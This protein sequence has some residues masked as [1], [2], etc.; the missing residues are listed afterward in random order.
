MSTYR[1][2]QLFSPR[3]VAVV[4]GSPRPTSPGRAVIRNLRDGG[5]KGPIHAVN[6]HHAE[7]EGTRAVK[8]FADLPQ[9]PDL[10]IVAAPAATVPSIIA[11]AAGRGTAAAIIITAGLGHGAGSLAETCEQTARKRGL[12]LVGPNCLGVLAPHAGLNASFAAHTPKPGDL[13]LISQSGAVAAGLVEWAANR[14]IGFSGIVS[15]GDSVDVDFGDLL[16]YF[17]IDRRTR[18]ILLYVESIRCPQ[19]HVGGPGRRPRETRACDQIRTPRPGGEGRAHPHRR[20]RRRRR[21]L[22]GRIPPRR[23]PARARSRRALRRR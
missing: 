6:P 22:R 18:A 15:L 13:A 4:G 19:V 11:A 16:D 5:F 17:A 2:D 8:T 12:R 23:L 10:A 21:G 20:T 14:A 9:T 1:L 3:S 7:I